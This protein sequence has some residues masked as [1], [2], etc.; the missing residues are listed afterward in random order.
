MT[1]AD[2]LSQLPDECRPVVKPRHKVALEHYLREDGTVWVVLVTRMP[3]DSSKAWHMTKGEYFRIQPKHGTRD[4]WIRE[5][6]PPTL[7]AEANPP[8]EHFLPLFLF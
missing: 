2:L 3:S 5:N 8:R 6:M 4:R 7:Q 1:T